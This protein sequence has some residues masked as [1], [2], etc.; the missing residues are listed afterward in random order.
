MLS[1]DTGKAPLRLRRQVGP[2][3]FV[4]ARDADLWT[5]LHDLPNPETTSFD[6][7]REMTSDMLLHGVAYA[8]IVR[9]DSRRLQSLW[10]LPPTCVRVDRDAQ[11]RKMWT[12]TVGATVQAFTF[13]P[14]LAADPGGSLRLAHPPR[15]RSDR[16]LPRA[17]AIHGQIL[18]ERRAAGRGSSRRPGPSRTPAAS[19]LKEA[20]NA[21]FQGSARAHSVAVLD[22]GFEVRPRSRRRTT[23]PS[24]TS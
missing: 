24:S 5:V 8:E 17:A 15:P 23:T 10:R 22:G 21:L 19:R 16:Q 11:R 7:V 9:A 4:D 14:G 12:V 1:E 13:D 20:W 2:D 6:F 18:S 3:S